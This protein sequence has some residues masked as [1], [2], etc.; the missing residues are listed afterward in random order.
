MMAVPALPQPALHRKAGT[1]QAFRIAP[2]DTNYFACLADPLADGVSFTLVV[3]VF[4]PGG[5]TPPNTHAVAEEA[6]FVLRGTGRARADG[7]V[8]DLGPGDTMVLRP[9][10]E[11]V[12]EN[13]GPGKLYC[14]TFMAPNEGFAELIR[15][16]TPVALE[17]EDIAVLTGAG[18]PAQAAGV[19]AKK[20]AGSK[21]RISSISAARRGAT[22]SRIAS[23]VAAVAAAALPSAPAGLRSCVS[24]PKP[25]LLT[26]IIDIPEDR[27][28]AFRRIHQF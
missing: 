2:G 22:W 17:A 12:V 20:P 3:E 21:P 16:G 6:F 15:H 19:A 1:W 4:Q 27:D 26:P 24:Q 13:T 11:H 23:P 14:L 10:V 9:G 8:I 18:R 25:V 5:A 7:V 28:P